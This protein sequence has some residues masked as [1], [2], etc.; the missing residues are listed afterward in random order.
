MAGGRHVAEDLAAGAHHV[1][2]DAAH[3]LKD[4][5]CAACVAEAEAQ[6][7]VAQVRAHVCVC[8]FVCA[9]VFM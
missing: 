6:Q 7:A 3:A 1:A 8:A 9:C 4:M 2:D 5:Q